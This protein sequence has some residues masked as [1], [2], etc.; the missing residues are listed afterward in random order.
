MIQIS[1]NDSRQYKHLTLENGIELVLVHDPTTEKSSACCDVR[2]GS[3]AD[4]HE[5]QGYEYS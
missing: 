3:M 1:H 5:M 4:P 2:I